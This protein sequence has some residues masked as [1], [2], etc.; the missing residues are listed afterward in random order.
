MTTTSNSVFSK[1]QTLLSFI[2]VA[3]GMHISIMFGVLKVQNINLLI[4]A[5][6]YLIFFL[7]LTSFVLPIVKKSD[8]TKVGLAFL[9]ITVFKMLFGVILV[10]FFI[11]NSGNTN[12]YVLS[13]FFGPF[14]IYLIAEVLI[15]LRE[16]NN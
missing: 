7:L 2:L 10:Y 1:L 6:A 12:L 5:H 3:V 14:F 16:L 8:K 4:S 9:A 13:N 11:K 15:A